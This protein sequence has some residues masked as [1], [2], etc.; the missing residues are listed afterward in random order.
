MSG[1][2]TPVLVLVHSSG[3]KSAPHDVRARTER[4]AQAAC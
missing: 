4:Q 3:L 2:E 1:S